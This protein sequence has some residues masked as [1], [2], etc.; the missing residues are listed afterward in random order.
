MG[1]A[2]ETLQPNLK[3]QEDLESRGIMFAAGPHWTE[4]SGIVYPHQDF[5]IAQRCTVGDAA[6]STGTNFTF[7][8][9]K[10]VR[11]TGGPPVPRRNPAS[12]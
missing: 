7:R 8:M 5:G 9:F 6:R 10:S 11:P 1:P 2:M 12:P 4:L 3:Y